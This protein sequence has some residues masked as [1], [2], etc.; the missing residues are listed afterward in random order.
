[1][2]FGPPVRQAVEGR[3]RVGATVEEGERLTSPIPTPHRVVAKLVKWAFVSLL[4]GLLPVLFKVVFVFAE[5]KPVTKLAILGSGELFLVA[6][7]LT[8]N[9]VGEIVFELHSPGAP[10][11]TNLAMQIF[12]AIAVITSIV[13]VAIGAAVYGNANGDS[14]VT[15]NYMD[16]SWFVLAAAAISSL[17]C[18]IVSEFK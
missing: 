11:N 8:A 2:P 3:R 7:G 18:V 1:L 13:I 16:L 6:A 9:G 10:M 17:S 15:D 12:R 14:T 4:I 5:D